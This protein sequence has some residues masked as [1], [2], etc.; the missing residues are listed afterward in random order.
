MKIDTAL[1]NAEN[2][3]CVAVGT[4]ELLMGASRRVALPPAMNRSRAVCAG[5]PA[6][7]LHTCQEATPSFE[8]RGRVSLRHLP[9]AGADC[10]H[11]KA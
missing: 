7:L 5:A 9:M 10:R 8:K 3:F 1:T 4:H 11:A 6:V 2:R